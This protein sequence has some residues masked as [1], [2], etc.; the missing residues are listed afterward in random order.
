MRVDLKELGRLAAQAA[1]RE[2]CG[3]LLG[4]REAPRLYPTKNLASSGYR[5]D[6]RVWLRVH[7]PVVGV[8]HSHLKGP[9]WPS[10]VDRQTC[11]PGLFYLIYSCSSGTAEVYQSGLDGLFSLGL[12]K[13]TSDE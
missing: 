7:E 2:C 10:L 4:D 12:A 1:P 13:D 9:P 11:W 3:L 6:A 5:I 8:Y